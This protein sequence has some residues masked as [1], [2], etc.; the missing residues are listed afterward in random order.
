M[1]FSD[2]RIIVNGEVRK[3]W[4]NEVVVYLK[5]QSW[6]LPGEIKENQ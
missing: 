6:N 3:I 5:I 2:N 1:T 4:K